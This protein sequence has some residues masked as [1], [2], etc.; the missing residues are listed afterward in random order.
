MCAIIDANVVGDVFQPSSCEAAR[1]F[2]EWVNTGRGRLVAGGKVLTELDENSTFKIWR[3]QA[4]LAGRIKIEKDD[5]IRER[6]NKLQSEGVLYRSDDLHVLAL[7]QVS[8]ARLLYSNDRDLQHDFKNKDLINNPRGRVYS[9]R[10]RRDF[11]DSHKS[12][13]RRT[14]L[15]CI[16]PGGA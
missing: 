14:D 9:T 6:V 15:C 5:A 16:G 8:G 11:A 1:K 13:L 7:A 10:E 4:T 12:L 3:Q 2:F